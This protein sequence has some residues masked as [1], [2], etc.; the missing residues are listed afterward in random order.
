MKPELVQVAKLLEQAWEIMAECTDWQYNR[1]WA[2]KA[3]DWRKRW[4][5]WL[6]DQRHAPREYVR[7]PAKR[8]KVAAR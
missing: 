4:S 8:R 3:E 7:K 5:W 6:E 1:E 2:A